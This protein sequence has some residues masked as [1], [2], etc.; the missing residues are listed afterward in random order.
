MNSLLSSL[1]LGFCLFVLVNNTSIAQNYN[2]TQ[3]K[4][5]IELTGRLIDEQSQ[6]VL[7]FATVVLLDPNNKETILEGTITDEN[8]IFELTVPVRPYTIRIDYLGFNSKEIDLG[9]VKSKKELGTISL[10]QD[11]AQLE[12]IDLVAEKTTVEIKLDKKVYN[13]GKDLTIGGGT[14]S[15][16]LD[17][18]PSL[19]VDVDGAIQ[20]RGNSDV[21]I[22]INGKPSALVGTDGTD[23]LRQLP[24]DAIEK[25]EVITSPSARYDAQ[26]SAGIVNIILKK[27]KLKGL[28]GSVTANIG[29]PETYGLN[30]SL[31]FRTKNVNFFL[32]GGYNDR[33]SLG[34][35]LND[36]E[37]RDNDGVITNSLFEK[38]NFDRN[39]KGY[40]INTGMEVVH[41]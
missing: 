40:N 28:N 12:E 35:S 3:S 27:N 9:L 15:D 17:N 30:G 31:N 34:N 39:S 21:R 41:Q 10:T 14:V 32:S 1:T 19:S 22:L 25:V 5:R 13:V 6:E 37:F 36:T 18:V 33:S 29:V 7:A 24:A 38:R 2:P 16:A 26:G 20:L 23:A 8:G 4:S 11:T